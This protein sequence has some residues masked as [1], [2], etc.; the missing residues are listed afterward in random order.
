MKI[1]SGEVKKRKI[2]VPK[3][4]RPTQDKVRAMIFDVLGEEIKDTNFIDLFAGSGA[5]GIEA[6]SRGAEKVIF[7]EESKKIREVLKENILSLGYLNKTKIISKDAL[8]WLSAV[9]KKLIIENYNI[10]FADP[11]YNKGW[12][13][14]LLHLINTE[15][16]LDKNLFIIEH[17]KHEPINIGKHYKFGD[18]V[19]T[20]I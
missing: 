9:N 1:I 11:P 19:T 6:L 14:K 8:K 7:V 4:I 5:V 12:I 15:F 3:G 2:E 13:E 10:I 18:T 17:S 20:F 16:C